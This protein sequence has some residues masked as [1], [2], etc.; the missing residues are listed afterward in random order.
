MRLLGMDA[1][2]VIGLVLAFKGFH[3]MF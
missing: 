3:S 1:L 2:I